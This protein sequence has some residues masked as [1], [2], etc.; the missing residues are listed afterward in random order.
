MSGGFF[1]SGAVGQQ[2][3]VG[4]QGAYGAQGPQGAQGPV[5]RPPDFLVPNLEEV[6]TVINF[7]ITYKLHL[8]RVN[9]AASFDSRGW[10]AIELDAAAHIR[11]KAMLEHWATAVGSTNVPIPVHNAGILDEVQRMISVEE[12]HVLDARYRLDDHKD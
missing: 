11:F 5:G 10:Y 8:L 1:G 7:A 12:S 4:A 3:A 9:A 2:G 6:L